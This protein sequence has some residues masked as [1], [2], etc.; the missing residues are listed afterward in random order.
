MAEN[1]VLKFSFALDQA[2]FDRVQSALQKLTAEATRLANVLKSVGGGGGGGPNI[3]GLN[4]LG[5]GGVGRPQPGVTG[6]KASP[7]GLNLGNIAKEAREGASALQGMSARVRTA[8]KDQI[9]DVKS[10]EQELSKLH[11]MYAAVDLQGGPAAAIRGRIRMIEGDLAGARAGRGSNLLPNIPLPGGQTMTGFE[12]HAG[13]QMTDR[14]RLIAASAGNPGAIPGRGGLFGTGLFSG[15]LLPPLPPGG[16]SMQNL[17]QQALTSTSFGAQLFRGGAAVTAGLGA[18]GWVGDKSVDLSQRQLTNRVLMG[19]AMRPAWERTRRVDVSDALAE[20]TFRTFGEEERERTMRGVYSPE[21]VKRAMGGTLN[22]MTGT[23]KEEQARIAAARQETIDRIK[24][25]GAYMQFER[26]NDYL[27]ST[28][29]SRLM[30]NQVLGV[31]I[32]RDR[33]GNIQDTYNDLYQKLH[34]RGFSIE[35]YAGAKVSGRALAGEAFDREFRSTIMSAQAG[36]YGGVAEALAGATRSAGGTNRGFARNRV[37]MAMGEDIDP[38]AGIALANAAFGYDRRSNLPGTGALAA[39]Q[40]GVNYGQGFMGDATDFNAVERYRGGLALGQRQFG[41]EA[42]GY[43]MGRNTISAIRALGPGASTYTQDALARMSP[44]ELFNLARGQGSKLANAYGFTP[45]DAQKQIMG[46]I[47]GRFASRVDQGGN[48]PMDVL[49]RKMH[50][51][52]RQGQDPRAV[53]TDLAKQAATGDKDAQRQLDA[54]DVMLSEG[55]TGG[56]QALEDAQ[57]LR[58]MITGTVGIRD[59]KGQKGRIR[60]AGGPDLFESAKRK[61]E[62]EQA[63]QDSDAVKA[64]GTEIVKAITDNLQRGL[65]IQSIANFQ[66]KVESM[67]VKADTVKIEKAKKGTVESEVGRIGERIFRGIQNTFGSES[68]ADKATPPGK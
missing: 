3:P 60:G 47:T 31:G 22:W 28:R 27:E 40:G 1:K 10:L 58:E 57:G 5:G 34:P 56:D 66:G 64:L 26:A 44:E 38:I 42:S 50:G 6:Q 46:S 23:T 16:L 36:G 29:G 65:T 9:Q 4:L 14:D 7:L 39:F 32:N 55:L 11:K 17:L 67:E 18:A 51:A 12:S 49:T 21:A 35:Q 48:R 63:K 41:A 59:R 30:A 68:P 8:L 19:S 62:A 33:N 37:E 54:L 20:A 13:R 61:Q 52:I 24:Q 2:S 25:T 45:E 43:Q 15:G 53:M